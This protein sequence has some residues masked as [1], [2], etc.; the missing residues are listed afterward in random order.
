[1]TSRYEVEGREVII[2]NT[3][4]TSIPHITA[5]IL[6]VCKEYEVAKLFPKLHFVIV[7]NNGKQ[8][9]YVISD[10]HENSKIHLMDNIEDDSKEFIYKVIVHEISHLWHFEDKKLFLRQNEAYRKLSIAISKKVKVETSSQKKINLASSRK[11]LKEFL[12]K[13][14]LEGF[15]EVCQRIVMQKLTFSEPN[16]EILYGIAEKEVLNIN[17]LWK[18]WIEEAENSLTWLTLIQEI[19]SYTKNLIGIHIL[20]SILFMN[21]NLSLED[22][23]HLTPFKMVQMYEVIIMQ[24]GKKPVFSITSGNGILDYRRMVR[25]LAAVYEASQ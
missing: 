2:E 25:E 12:L 1:M 4:T 13:I 8:A 9:G 10:S 11:Y 22:L 20:Y 14:I 19:E 7:P 23:R 6:G 17:I 5:S 16:F 3:T 24:K 21:H 18:K 15:A